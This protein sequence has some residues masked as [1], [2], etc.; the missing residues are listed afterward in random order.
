MK[1]SH[2]IQN[3]MQTMWMKVVLVLKGLLRR[4][5][6]TTRKTNEWD[7]WS[8]E[9]CCFC[10]F[11][12]LSGFI[13]CLVKKPKALEIFGTITAMHGRQ[14]E[15]PCRFAFAINAALFVVA[16]VVLIVCCAVLCV[17]RHN[18]PL[19]D[20]SHPVCWHI[21]HSQN[22]VIENLSTLRVMPCRKQGVVT[23]IKRD[24]EPTP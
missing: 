3:F 7:K 16:V 5:K 20:V 14:F 15:Y 22:D 8:N 12:F 24:S 4:R 1:C 13:F 9:V 18:F 6:R 19:V 23:R 17:M 21:W 2:Q 11:H 10:L